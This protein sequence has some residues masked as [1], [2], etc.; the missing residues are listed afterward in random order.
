MTVEFFVGAPFAIDTTVDNDRNC[1]QCDEMK[2]GCARCGVGRSLAPEGC[3]KCQPGTSKSTAAAYPLGQGTSA[4]TFSSWEASNYGSSSTTCQ[5][6]DPAVGGFQ[7]EEGQAHCKTVCNWESRWA[8]PSQECGKCLE[9]WFA[10]VCLHASAANCKNTEYGCGVSGV[11]IR[12]VVVVVL[13][14]VLAVVVVVG[15]D[16]LVLLRLLFCLCC[17]HSRLCSDFCRGSWL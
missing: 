5:S 10:C 8:F 4:G 15:L 12:I 6:C 11:G 3:S 17:L 13:L 1:L 7:D 9:G 14:L 16:L 2:I